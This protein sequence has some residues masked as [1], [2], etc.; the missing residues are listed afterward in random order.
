MILNMITTGAMTRL[1]Y[2]YE[3]LMVNV[4]MKNSKLVE[5]GIRIL[6]SACNI[7]RDT[8]VAHHQERRPKRARR[9]GH[10]QG[11]SRQ[12]GSRPPPRQIRRQRPPRHRR[13]RPRTLISNLKF[14]L[15]GI[16]SAFLLRVT[17]LMKKA[18]RYCTPRF[19]TLTLTPK[20]Y[21]SGAGTGS[22]FLAAG[23]SLE[24]FAVALSLALD[25]E[26]N[27]D[28]LYLGALTYP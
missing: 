16:S 10:A 18:R 19:F 27:S 20:C 9:P 23:G 3:N 24:S 28:C 14:D 1:G 7:D 5:R 6:M 11:Q 21:C 13:Q 26:A 8:A 12:A 15:S 17:L 25:I 22:F 4:H 2:V